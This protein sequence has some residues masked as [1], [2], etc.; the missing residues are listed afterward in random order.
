TQLQRP[1][2]IDRCGHAAAAELRYRRPRGRGAA[3]LPYRAPAA[4]SSLLWSLRFGGAMSAWIRLDTVNVLELVDLEVVSSS[5]EV[6]RDP[7]R[8]RTQRFRA[9]SGFE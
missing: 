7:A 6:V 4:S 2:R 9:G 8:Q 5:S 3:A 1:R